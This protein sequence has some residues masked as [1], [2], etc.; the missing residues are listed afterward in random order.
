VIALEGQVDPP[1][2]H[3]HPDSQSSPLSIELVALAL[4][5]FDVRLDSIDV[6]SLGLGRA[7]QAQAAAMLSRP[8]SL[9]QR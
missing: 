2:R 6:V 5:Q 4:R 8:G 7:R 3:H 9:P 1:G